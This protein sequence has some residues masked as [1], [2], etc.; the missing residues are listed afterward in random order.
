M[1]V[2]SS[3]T[4]LRRD[5]RKPEEV[6]DIL[7]QFGCAEGADGSVLYQLGNT[8][9]LATVVGPADA[10]E[11]DDEEGDLELLEEPSGLDC[12]F[13]LSSFSQS[14]RKSGK[15]D[16]PRSEEYAEYMEMCYKM[17]MFP[18]K[19]AESVV[20]V[21]CQVLQTDGSHLAAALT[22]GTLALI[23]AGIPIKDIIVACSATIT[24]GKPIV[25]IAS[26]EESHKLPQLTVA[27]IPR[28]RE[29]VVLDTKNRFHKD[30]FNPLLN[31]ALDGCQKVFED[32][33]KIVREHVKQSDPLLI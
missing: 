31:A 25:D 18:H 28:T 9:I 3:L 1:D 15:G 8:K 16:D 7:C 10:G 14:D 11:N 30:L 4:G 33:E 12:H 2:M 26:H 24:D 13:K 23:D 6:R 27:A 20:K 17:I 32:V 5:G 22:A 29:V 19:T 21:T